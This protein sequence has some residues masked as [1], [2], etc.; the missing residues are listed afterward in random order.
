MAENLPVFM[1]CNILEEE[2]EGYQFSKWPLHLTVIPWFRLKEDALPKTLVAIEETAKK[3]GSFAIKSKGNAWYGPRGDIPVTEVTDVAGK[4]T[5]L[6][7]ELVHE[8]QGNAGDIIDL[9][10]TGDNYS[11][12]V[13][14]SK[15]GKSIGHDQILRCSNIT[16]VE[17][18]QRKV[19]SKQVI[20]VISLVQ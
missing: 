5:E 19:E 16:V 9:T 12:H 14:V 18:T 15:D 17:K 2:H 13:S 20:K 10:H 4:L 11:P 1:V 6:H 7:N 8:I 3:V